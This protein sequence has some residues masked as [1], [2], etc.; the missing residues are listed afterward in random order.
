MIIWLTIFS[1]NDVDVTSH[2][3][4]NI[5]WAARA[6]SSIPRTLSPVTNVVHFEDPIGD[7]QALPF[8]T[9]QAVKVFTLSVRS[10]IS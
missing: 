7:R 1:H 3:L 10:S 9:C 4:W 2:Y 5:Q 6:L 8:E